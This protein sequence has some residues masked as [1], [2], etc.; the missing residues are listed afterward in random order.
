FPS[1]KWINRTEPIACPFSANL[2]L[3]HFYLYNYLRTILYRTSLE[4]AEI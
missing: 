1:G 4:N 2:D 3:L